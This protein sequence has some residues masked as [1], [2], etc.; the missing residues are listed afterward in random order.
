MAYGHPANGYVL[1]ARSYSRLQIITMTSHS[2]PTLA[3]GANMASKIIFAT[4]LILSTIVSVSILIILTCIVG[5]WLI[6]AVG[7]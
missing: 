3:A 1:P 6:K 4:M 7:L 2:F 5:E